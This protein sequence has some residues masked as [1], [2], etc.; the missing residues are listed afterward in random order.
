[1][2]RAIQIS[3]SAVVLSALVA[4][5]GG[6]SKEA[7]DWASVEATLRAYLPK[8]AEAYAEGDASGLEGLAAPKEIARINKGIDELYA[9]GRTLE[10]EFLELTV[11]KVDVWGYANAFVNTV[12]IWNIR[13]YATGTNALVGEDLGKSER[14]KYQFKR[15]GDE[16][17]VLYRTISG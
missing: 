10:P 14:V 3:L 7:A 4:C 16:W 11:E 1:M 5:G 2:R 6:E 8:L 13:S 9:L 17:L 15:E 12:E